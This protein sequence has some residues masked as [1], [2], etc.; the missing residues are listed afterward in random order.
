MSRSRTLSFTVKKKTGDAFDAI[1]N[2]PAKMMSDAVQS[3]DGWWKFMTPRGQARLK[4]NE[5]KKLGI[6]DYM[7]IDEESK[8]NVP[9]RVVPSGDESEIIIT[10]VKPDTITDEQFNQRMN[11]IGQAFANLKSLIETPM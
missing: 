11:E 4:F 3:N 7:Y 5:N 8:W 2:A 6:L 9:M 10:L 1:L